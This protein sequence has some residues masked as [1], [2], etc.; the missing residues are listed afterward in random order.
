MKKPIGVLAVSLLMSLPASAAPI[1]EL[2]EWSF[3]VTKDGTTNFYDCV[4]SAGGC[5]VFQFVPPQF[6]AQGALQ[7]TFTGAGNYVFAAF[8]DYELYDVAVDG[9]S[10]TNEY[11]QVAGA[12]GAGVSWEIDEPGYV[13]GDIFSHV[14]ATPPGLDNTNAIN[15]GAF[16][17]GDDV[18]FALARAFVLAADQEAILQITISE[19]AP[20]GGFYLQQTDL[21]TS[22]NLYFYT[23]MQVR[24]I[25]GGGAEIPEPATYVSLTIGATALMAMHLR[26]RFRNG[27]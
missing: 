13:F 6:G 20:S 10:F 4:P 25:G 17:N 11:G 7:A 23:A 5:P 22:Q 16:P 14:S 2:F 3:N 24:D 12:P 18:S 19:T 26:R 1:V 21:A 9:G 27:R 15:L 8:Y